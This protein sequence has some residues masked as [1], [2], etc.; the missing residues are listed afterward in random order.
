MLRDLHNKPLRESAIEE[1][2]VHKPYDVNKESEKW[3]YGILKFHVLDMETA[4]DEQIL[5]K[6]D[7]LSN[8]IKQL[9]KLTVKYIAHRYWDDDIIIYRQPHDIELLQTVPTA[10]HLLAD[11]NKD[12]V[13][14]MYPPALH[15]IYFPL[16]YRGIKS[17]NNW[18]NPIYA[19]FSMFAKWREQ[20][21]TL[22]NI[23]SRTDFSEFIIRMAPL[24]ASKLLREKYRCVIYASLKELMRQS[25]LQSSS[26]VSN[27]TDAITWLI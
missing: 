4:V 8:I 19:T 6:S 2:F 1:D 3:T 10:K 17:A 13:I 7:N 9:H 24:N 22:K 15:R 16:R 14:C 27:E 18:I 21:D 12:N 23:R 20:L 11:Y 25:V 5:F 26:N